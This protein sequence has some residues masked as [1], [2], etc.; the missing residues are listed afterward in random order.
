MIDGKNVFDQ[1]IKRCKNHF[2]LLEKF[3]LVKAM[4]TQPVVYLII[5]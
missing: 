4:I 3:I 5:L 1:P 2:K